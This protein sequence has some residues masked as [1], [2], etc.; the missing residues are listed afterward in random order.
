MGA[1]D[2][3]KRVAVGDREG[4]V[5]EGGGLVDHLVGVGGPAEEGEVGGDG[6]FGV[7]GGAGRGGGGGVFPRRS[8]LGVG[9]VGHRRQPR[10]TTVPAV[11]VV[12]ELESH[13][14]AGRPCYNGVVLGSLEDAVEEPAAGFGDAEESPAR[15]RRRLRP[16]SSRGSCRGLPNKRWLLLS[17]PTILVTCCGSCF[18]LSGNSSLSILFSAVVILSAF[19]FPSCLISISCS[20]ILF[21]GFFIVFFILLFLY[22]FISFIFLYYFTFIFFFLSSLFFIFSFFSFFFSFMIFLFFFS[23]FFF[24]FFFLFFFYLF[25]FLFLFFVIFYFFPIIFFLFLFLFL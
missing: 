5:A 3:G 4:A 11:W 21:L 19:V 25:I 16:P 7:V 6:E 10:S 1:H 9:G 12:I 2:V 8:D 22:L 24:L 13:T 23:F 17:L 14:R 18:F 20:F 15:R